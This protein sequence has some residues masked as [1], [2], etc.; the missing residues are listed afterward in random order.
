[1]IVKMA[2]TQQEYNEP[3][4]AMQVAMD[5]GAE[6]FERTL[7]AAVNGTLVDLSYVLDGDC[8]L[9][10]LGLEDERAKR[11][12]Q[13]T[14]AHILGQAVK[15]VYPTAKLVRLEAESG[16]FYC[17][18]CFASAPDRSALGRIEEEMRSICRA[19]LGIRYEEVSRTVA[20]KTMRRFGEI[21]RVQDVEAL[22]KGTRVRIYSIGDF[23]D[24][25]TGPHLVRT[26]LVADCLLTSLAPLVGDRKV[27]R[28]A[29]AAYPTK[30]VR[31]VQ[32]AGVSKRM[33]VRAPQRK[34]NNM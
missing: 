13:H 15:A 32:K 5:R 24:V 1:M 27:W 18:I 8:T 4:T 3:L 9:E 11:V 17:D 7:V 25:S 14:A 22:P 30:A 29:G 33:G 20:I 16:G 19:D 23:V 31:A 34:R 28:I 6:V 2:D 12:Y 10:L 21:Y 26:G